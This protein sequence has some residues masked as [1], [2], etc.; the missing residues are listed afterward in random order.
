[1]D[2]TPEQLADGWHYD[3]QGAPVSGRVIDFKTRKVIAGCDIAPDPPA[4]LVNAIVAA[5]VVPINFDTMLTGPGAPSPRPGTFVPVVETVTALTPLELFN[6]LYIRTV[7]DLAALLMFYKSTGHWNPTA[8]ALAR[9]AADNLK[10]V[11]A[12]C[13]GDNNG[14]EDTRREGSGKSL[15]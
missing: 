14:D 8:E 3:A 7:T 13:A 9:R 5:T 15:A 4:D 10:A 1:M 12:A 2:L 11:C 6:T